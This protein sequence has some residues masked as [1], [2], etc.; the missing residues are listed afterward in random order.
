M[1]ILK[2]IVPC[3]TNDREK[4]MLIFVTERKVILLCIL[5]GQL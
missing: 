1:S 5:Q 4:Q 3:Y 2:S